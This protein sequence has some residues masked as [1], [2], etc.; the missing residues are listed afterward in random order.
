MSKGGK[1]AEAGVVSLDPPKRRRQTVSVD[2][3]RCMICQDSS[4]KELMNIQ[5]TCVPKLRDTMNALQDQTYSGLKDDI[6]N[7]TWITDKTPKWHPKCRNWYILKKS[8]KLAEKKRLGDREIRVNLLP[9]VLLAS[10]RAVHQ[11]WTYCNQTLCTCIRC[12]NHLCHMQQTVPPRKG[13]NQQGINKAK[14]TSNT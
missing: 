13:T 12:Q 7:E 5:T 4:E 9:L 6:N 2:Y 10:L 14:P 3:T 8:Y 11:P 1:R